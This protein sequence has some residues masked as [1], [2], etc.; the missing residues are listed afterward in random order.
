MHHDNSIPIL[1]LK[2]QQAEQSARIFGGGLERYGFVTVVNHGISHEALQRAYDVARRVFALPLEVKR[3][4]ETPENGRMTGYASYGTE[5]A[6]ED[7]SPDLKEFWHVRRNAEVHP[8]LFPDE[9]PE[10]GETFDGLFDSLYEVSKRLLGLVG[11]YLGK[12][13]GHFENMVRGGDTLLRLLRYPELKGSEP[14]MRASA[15]EDI[16]L[17]TLLVGA[18]ASGLEIKTRGGQ[19]LPVHNTPD[20]IICNAGDML[21]IHSFGRIRSTTHRVVNGDGKERYSIPFF[22]H[23]RADVPLVLAGDYLQSRLEEIGAKPK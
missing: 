19:W 5:H 18:T 22:V 11:V 21:Q 6:K 13:E 14:G 12:P 3:R 23:P 1:D 17:L 2:A 16:N 7:P 8:M 15:H 9:I 20:A 10:F 4:Y